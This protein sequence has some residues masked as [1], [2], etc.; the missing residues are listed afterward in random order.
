M[1]SYC[2]ER[3]DGFVLRPA[4]VTGD[5]PGSIVD[6]S[7]EKAGGGG[8]SPSLATMFSVVYRPS[9]TQFH[10]T[11]F[12]NSWPVEICLRRN[13]ARLVS[14][15]WGRIAFPSCPLHFCRSGES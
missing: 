9:K 4:D 7:P 14:V 6:S 1:D 8:S 2:S 5:S 10:S 15:S 3:R 11:S 13:E 12:Q